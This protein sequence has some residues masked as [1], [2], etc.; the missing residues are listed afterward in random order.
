MCINVYN[1][2]G[3]VLLYSKMNCYTIYVIY[4]YK[5]SGSRAALMSRDNIHVV[6]RVV[7]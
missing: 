3:A 5:I 7:T 4:A 2:F 6:L 1:Q